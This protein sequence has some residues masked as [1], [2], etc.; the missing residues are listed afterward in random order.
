MLSVYDRYAIKSSKV[1][2]INLSKNLEAYFKQQW[3]QENA[4][5][6]EQ[7]NQRMEKYGSFSQS[8]R[9]F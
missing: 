5:T 1:S 2:K 4:K 3:L 7:Q 9:R 8:V 6:I